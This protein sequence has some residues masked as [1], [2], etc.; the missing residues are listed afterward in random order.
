MAKTS[1]NGAPAT[2]FDA[3]DNIDIDDMF[4]DGGDDLFEGLAD[5]LGLDQMGDI[6]NDIG[7]SVAE[8]GSNT[9]ANTEEDTV[10]PTAPAVA[11]EPPKRRKTKRKPKSPILL[12]EEDDASAIAIGHA[13]Q[14]EMMTSRSGSPFSAQ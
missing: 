1:R 3:L 5:D 14:R 11:D 9:G 4:A 2:S 6:T 7:S 12:D 13:F 10:L 8:E